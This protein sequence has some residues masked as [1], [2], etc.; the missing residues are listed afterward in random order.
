MQKLANQS[1]NLFP[2]RLS[3]GVVRDRRLKSCLSEYS[4]AIVRKKQRF[5][6]Q[7]EE[8][9]FIP[10]WHQLMVNVFVLY[11]FSQYRFGTIHD[12]FETHFDVNE[13]R[14]GFHKCRSTFLLV[15]Q[16][17]NPS[18]VRQL[19][20]T[21]SDNS[22]AGPLVYTCLENAVNLRIRTKNLKPVLFHLHSTLQ[23]Y[24]LLT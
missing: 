12:H 7:L 14:F 21:H 15:L 11:P 1:S 13:K 2:H 18:P 3:I 17:R 10:P 23:S 19:V 5:G 20:R 8:S 16:C 6:V 22:P 4:I 24:T 9:T